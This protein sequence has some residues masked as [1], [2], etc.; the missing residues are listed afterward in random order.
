MKIKGYHISIHKKEKEKE[1][2]ND[3]FIQHINQN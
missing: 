1:R 3:Y 2:K